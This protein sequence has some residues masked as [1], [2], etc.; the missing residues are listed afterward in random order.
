M[1][2]T[3]SL[4]IQN[5]VLTMMQMNRHLRSY[6]NPETTAPTNISSRK[7]IKQSI[8]INLF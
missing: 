3:C 7:L 8:N 5:N 4:Q 1:L 6:E 2:L